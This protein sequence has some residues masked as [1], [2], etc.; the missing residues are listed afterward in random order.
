MNIEVIFNELGYIIKISGKNIYTN[1]TVYSLMSLLFCW[2]FIYKFAFY[3]VFGVENS[4][5]NDQSSFELVVVKA[6]RDT[7]KLKASADCMVISGAGESPMII[8]RHFS[9]VVYALSRGAEIV[10][11]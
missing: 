6:T 9:C 4:E 1:F 11:I 5:K 10:K 7:R 8:S 3:S 2:F